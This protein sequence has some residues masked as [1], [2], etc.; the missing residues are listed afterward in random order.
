MELFGGADEEMQDASQSM[1]YWMETLAVIINKLKRPEKNKLKK[2][3]KSWKNKEIPTDKVVEKLSEILNGVLKIA[4]NDKSRATE[5]LTLGDFIKHKYNKLVGQKIVLKARYRELLLLEFGKIENNGIKIYQI[6]R[7]EARKKPRID[8]DDKFERR[9]ILGE[10]IDPLLSMIN[11][12]EVGSFSI[13][14]SIKYWTDIIIA[15]SE[16]V[17]II[18][19]SFL[20]RKYLM[21]EL[22]EFIYK[23]LLSFL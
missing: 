2:W 10:Q 8:T 15:F 23:E 4:I 5:D 20:H 17:F 7:K 21:N 6:D 14:N 11:P 16:F 9:V 12:K 18:T 22:N 19:I 13:L 1:I 3:F